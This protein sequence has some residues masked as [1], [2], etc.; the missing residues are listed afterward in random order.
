MMGEVSR[1]PKKTI[2]GPYVF[3]LLWCSP[4]ISASKYRQDLCLTHSEN[5]EERAG[6][7]ITAVLWNKK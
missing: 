5:G 3:N 1:V 4:Y 7:A 6:E 2:V